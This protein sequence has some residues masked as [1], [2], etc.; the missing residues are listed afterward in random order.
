[1][2]K[3]IPALAVFLSLAFPLYAQQADSVQ[4]NPY[5]LN[6]NYFKSYWWDTRD[7]AIAPLHWKKNQWI[8]FAGV[9]AVSTLVYF[10]DGDVQETFQKNRS[11]GGDEFVKYAIE[12][13][14]DGTYS[15]PL[16]GAFYLEGLINKNP[17]SKKMALL[18]VKTFLVA[19]AYTRIPKYL[20]QRHRPDDDIPP[21]PNLWEGPFQGLSGYY[22]FPS[23]HAV[24]AFAMATVIASEYSDHWYVPIV[25]YSL[26]SAVSLSR[27]YDNKHWASDVLIGG[28]FGY[29][30]GK[31][32]YNKDNWLNGGK[33][34]KKII[35]E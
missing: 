12:P 23:G 20:A 25:S 13:W 10:Y 3:I 4:Q 1:L 6:G 30:M 7:I 24:S 21:D 34:K 18:G 11:H 29:A 22:S 2:K 16:M 35:A 8:G 27:I 17:R 19:G 33:K 5:R 32:I 26:A 14:G 9:T 28:A 31:L 15:L